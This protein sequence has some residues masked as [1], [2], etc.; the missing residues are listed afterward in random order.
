[1]YPETPRVLRTD[2]P[3]NSVTPVCRETPVWSEVVGAV[4]L[5]PQLQGLATYSIFNSPR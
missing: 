1:M 3:A 2:A 4:P 5:V